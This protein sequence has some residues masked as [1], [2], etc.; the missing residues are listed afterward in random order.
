MNEDFVE[1]IFC[2]EYFCCIK[3]RCLFFDVNEANSVLEL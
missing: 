2:E 3:T 1:K